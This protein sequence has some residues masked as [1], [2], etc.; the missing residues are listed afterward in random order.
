MKQKIALVT[1]L[2]VLLTGAGWM[3]S[4]RAS[5]DV[6]VPV[7]TATAAA[8]ATDPQL[9]A[10]RTSPQ[11]QAF[12]E[13]QEF[14]ARAK[15]FLRDAPKLG[16]VERSEQ[17]RAL[18]T[19]IG[20]YE[21]DGGLSAGEALVLRSGL[22]KATVADEAQQT[23]QIADL[24]ERYRARADRRTSEYLA[25]QQRDPRFQDYKARERAVVAEVMAMR[26]I[27]DGLSRD[28]YLRR[29]LQQER[30]RIYR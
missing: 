23:A 12:R 13:R 24:M 16:A 18:A 3:V 5:P 27:P 26:D 28:E 2:L 17:A 22:I 7:D 4:Q 20:K 21:H 30:E 10:L 14:E 19:S 25:Q 1:G 8:V 15:R 29:R 9:A 6:S 11:A